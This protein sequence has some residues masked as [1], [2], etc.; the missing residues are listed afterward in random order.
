MT[1]PIAYV[2]ATTVLEIR[3]DFS[4]SS[5]LALLNY[6]QMGDSASTRL[7]LAI[8]DF[9]NFS[10]KQGHYHTANRLLTLGKW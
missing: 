6:F 5:D 8:V 2:E 4:L 3:L 1:V 9:F 7:G 10:I